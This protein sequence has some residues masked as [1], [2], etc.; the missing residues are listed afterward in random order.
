MDS[1]VRVFAFSLD[2]L[3]RQQNPRLECNAHDTLVLCWSWRIRA[4]RTLPVPEDSDGGDLACHSIADLWGLCKCNMSTFLRPAFSTDALTAE[5]PGWCCPEPARIGR[6]ARVPQLEQHASKHSSGAPT[7][8]VSSNSSGRGRDLACGA[9]AGVGNGQGEVHPTRGFK[10]EVPR[11]ISTKGYEDH[12]QQAVQHV[13]QACQ[14][15]THATFSTSKHTFGALNKGGSSAVAGQDTGLGS[16]VH[17]GTDGRRGRGWAEM[18]DEEAADA[19]IQEIAQQA[20]GGQL[21][22][23]EREVLECVVQGR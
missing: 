5:Q 8:G 19:L 15:A 16:V 6:L 18:F 3:L 2:M 4:G 22:E 17:A 23:E 12:T 9:D 11:K 1:Q 7:A 21:T 14:P 20:Q 13:Q 10:A